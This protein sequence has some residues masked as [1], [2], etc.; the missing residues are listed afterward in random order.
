[1][2]TQTLQETPDANRRP[3]VMFGMMVSQGNIGQ[4]EGTASAFAKVAEKGDMLGIQTDDLIRDRAPLKGFIEKRMSEA[5]GSAFV[6]DK[7]CDDAWQS[8]WPP[9]SPRLFYTGKDIFSYGGAFN[10]LLVLT[11][12]AKAPVLVRVDAGTAPLNIELFNV[13]LAKHIALFPQYA[14]AS[15]GYGGDKGDEGRLALR[16]LKGLDDP[17]LDKFRRLVK[18]HTAVDP[19]HQLTGGACL[20]LR[21]ESGPPAIAFPG[22]LPVWASDDAFFQW[23]APSFFVN[24]PDQD[25]H[26]KKRKVQPKD[27]MIVHRK[28]PGQP[29]EGPEYLARLACAAALTAIHRKANLSVRDVPKLDTVVDAGRAFLDELREFFPDTVRASHHGGAL[30]RLHERALGLVEGYENYIDL[31]ARWREV[32]DQIAKIAAR[33]LP[34]NICH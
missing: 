23:S 5:W 31:T 2:K 6:W 32:P 25:R 27:P 16:D 15:G 19:Y 30:K 28:D 11:L 9:S 4:A 20:T 7:Q 33:S 24:A 34:F 17:A 13:S 3:Q 29:L 26:R 22:V 1:M 12:I 10:R 14:V 18:K 21:P 8:R